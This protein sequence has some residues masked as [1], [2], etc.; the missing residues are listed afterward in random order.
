M[1][2]SP[3]PAAAVVPILPGGQV[4]AGVRS[5]HARSLTGYFAFPG[6]AAELDDAEL[7]LATREGVEALER[8]CAL[9]E[10]GEETGHWSLCD[11][12]GGPPSEAAA[13]LFRERIEADAPLSRALSES[14]LL[15]DDRA[16]IP[17]G[18][19]RMRRF[20]LRQFLLPLGSADM[21]RTA[22][23]PELEHVG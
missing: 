21:V 23:G 22:A 18:R 9:R 20:D 8:A 12:A 11:D 3:L 2:T 1:P 17:L 7:P 4:L 13:A 19:W 5:D 6:G 16:L 10:L 15:L 14:G